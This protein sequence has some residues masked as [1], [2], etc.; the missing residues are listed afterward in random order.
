MTKGKYDHYKIRGKKNSGIGKYDH[1]KLRGK[2]RPKEICDKIS[3]SNLGKKSSEE[4]RRKLS[5]SHKEPRPWR[6]GIPLSEK[7]KRKLSES[8]IGKLTGE[9]NPNWKDGISKRQELRWI[10]WYI[11]RQTI[12]ER[13]RFE[14]QKCHKDHH[15]VELIVHH[16][17]EN[18]NNNLK[19]NLITL[20]R[21]CH[22][23]THWE[24]RLSR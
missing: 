1:W 7:H 24:A 5:I 21:S 9:K 20:C 8:H 18:K 13:D 4:T 2:R 12:F 16:K 14:C 10:S 15:E 3:K 19:E 23:R 6:Q 22:S 11:L 17:D